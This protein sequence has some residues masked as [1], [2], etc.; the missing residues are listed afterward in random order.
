MA[1]KIS[2]F[3][4]LRQLLMRA[5]RRFSIIGLLLWNNR[6]TVSVFWSTDLQVVRGSGNLCIAMNSVCVIAI[7]WILDRPAHAFKENYSN[8]VHTHIKKIWLILVHVS[9][10]GG[11][12]PRVMW[13]YA[14]SYTVP[15]KTGSD[16]G[17]K[18]FRAP[19]RGR[20]G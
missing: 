4:S 19:Q 9:R 18:F 14:T 1:S 3:S 5:R 10:N 2:V 15:P 11:Y 20:T 12:R 7:I 6:E 13:E 16:L 8:N 17:E